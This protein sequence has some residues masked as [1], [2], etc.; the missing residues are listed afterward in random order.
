LRQNEQYFRN[1]IR[2]V[3]FFRSFV[4]V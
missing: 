3:C 4:A 2:P 1:S